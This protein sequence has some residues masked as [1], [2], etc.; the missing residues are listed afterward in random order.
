M[1]ADAATEALLRRAQGQDRNGEVT[2]RDF[3]VGIIDTLG[4][5]TGADQNKYLKIDG[6]DPAPNRPGVQIVFASPE[7]TYEK[8]ELPIVLVRRDDLSPAMTRWHPGRLKYRRPAATAVPVVYGAGTSYERRG[9]DRMEEQQTTV[10]FDLSYTI[11]VLARYRGAPLQ[12]H[13]ANRIVQY[14]LRTYQPYS[15][16]R[17]VD[18]VGDVRPY[19]VFMDGSSSLD[20]IQGVTERLIG[21]AINLRV[22]AALD[23]NDPEV[24]RTVTKPLTVVKGLP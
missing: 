8:Y 1:A 6:V 21:S 9:Y 18:S 22:E 2:L 20:T 12:T 15:V 14:I 4:A 24:F 7:D 10:P 17:V 11:T 16:V 5:F 19:D 23:L 3:D 13:Q